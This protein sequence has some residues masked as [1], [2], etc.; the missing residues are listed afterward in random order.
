MY[1]LITR[2]NCVF[3]VKAKG[4]LTGASLDYREINIEDERWMLTLIKQ[5]GH[6]TVPQIY[7]PTGNHVGGYTELIETLE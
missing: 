1:T 3:C 6:T 2:N 5:A 4:A 7:D